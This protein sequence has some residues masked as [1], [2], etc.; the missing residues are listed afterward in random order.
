MSILT[1]WAAALRS[2]DPADDP[3]AAAEF[4]RVED[5]VVSFGSRRILDG[6][7]M[8]LPH[9][10][11]IAVTGPNGCGKTTLLRCI[12]GAMTPDSGSVHV[13]GRPLSEYSVPR[14]ARELAVVSQFENMVD[15]V[16]VLDIV[17]MGCGVRRSTLS[18]YTAHDR[19]LALGCLA[20]VGLTGSEHRIAA[21]LSGG[22]RQRVLIARALAQRSRA[23]LLDEPTNHLDMRYQHEV[24][25]CIGKEVASQLV[26]LHDLN[27]VARYSDIVV[28]LDGG[29]VAAIGAPEEVLTPELIQEVYGMN[30]WPVEVNDIRQFVFDTRGHHREAAAA[31]EAGIKIRK[32]DPIQQE[33]T[34]CSMDH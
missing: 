4:I 32:P 18:A 16:R 8:E 9:G 33:D 24:L 29:A 3:D 28:M 26:V 27:M 14:L 2:H 19:D 1:T 6:I 31:G 20:T 30:A 5:L 34:T 21:T 10:R 12:S 23:M 25:Q 7:S 17:L 13:N 22:E 11:R 15:Q